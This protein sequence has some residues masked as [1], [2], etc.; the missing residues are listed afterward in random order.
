MKDIPRRPR[1][2]VPALILLTTV[3]ILLTSAGTTTGA[4]AATGA[5]AHAAIH[6]AS[7]AL[8]GMLTLHQAGRGTVVVNI[9][10]SRLTAGFHG[11]HIHA[12]GICDPTTTD[13]AGNP[14]PFLSA[15]PH[16]NPAGGGHGAHAGDLPPL[17]A[18][19]QGAASATVRTDRFTVASLFDSDGS[20]VI[21]HAAPDNLAHIPARYVS[22]T[23]GAPGPDT[24]SLGTG[25]AGARTGCGVITRQ[26]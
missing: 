6:D 2:V 25:D 8:L 16:M 22:S 4:S 20:A 21:V 1:S 26:D 3:P 12:I 9:Q 14:A 7:G 10:A 15:G 17:I 5:T 19:R 11:F 24:A 23:T 18:S 13:P